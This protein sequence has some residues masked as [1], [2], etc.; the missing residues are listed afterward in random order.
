MDRQL[1]AKLT[2]AERH[3]M[4]TLSWRS[5]TYRVEH[6]FVVKSEE[7]LMEER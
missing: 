6:V 2:V 1:T 4:V 3:T 5:S 7:I